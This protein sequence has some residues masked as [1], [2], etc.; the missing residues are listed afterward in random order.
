VNLPQIELLLAEIITVS[1]LLLAGFRL[2]PLL[3]LVPVYA[4]LG[5]VFYTAAF[6]AAGVYVELAPGLIVSPGSVALFPAILFTVLCVYITEDVGEAR[7]LIFG[8]VLTDLFVALLGGLTALQLQAPGAL[9]RFHLPPDL[10]ITNPRISTVSILALFADTLVIILLYELISRYTRSLL[11]RIYISTSI[12]MAFDTIV[13]ITGSYVESPNYLTFLTSA[14]IGKLLAAIPYTILFTIYLSFFDSVAFDASVE[15]RT[16]GAMFRTLTYRQKYELLQ[17]QS[18]RDPMTRL[19]NRGFFDAE[20]DM[21][22]V[23]SLRAQTS[24]AILMADVD[25]FKRVND[26]HGHI[27]G[28]RVLTA[29]A[30]CLNA[31]FR[32]S[33]YVCRYGGEEFA[34]LLPKT[35][36]RNAIALAEKTRRSV[37]ERPCG[38]AQLR[39]TV[40]IGVAIFPD[41]A[42]SGHEL[43][44]LVDQRLYEGKSN[45]RNQVI[46]SNPDFTQVQTA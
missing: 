31:N 33:D 25:H 9:N 18:A 24:L 11:A 3:G 22:I 39:V 30:E 5:V 23:S 44:E 19:Y 41:E 46:P 40:T 17:A 8:L 7:K 2:R 4:V 37:A 16:I 14:M 34:I 13:F 43:M 15:A 26:T 21:Q 29:V 27:E 1:V 10:F 45:G 28:D 36:L 32:A 38:E 42:V 20:L 35:D 6:L 12:T